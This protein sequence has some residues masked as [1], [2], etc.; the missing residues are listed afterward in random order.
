MPPCGIHFTKLKHQIL[1]V[2]HTEPSNRGVN[3]RVSNF[4]PVNIKLIQIASSVHIFISTHFTKKFLDPTGMVYS[5]ATEGDSVRNI[6]VLG[7]QQ[8]GLLLCLETTGVSY[9]N[10]TSLTS[11]QESKPKRYTPALS[12]LLDICHEQKDMQSNCF[13]VTKD[14]HTSLKHY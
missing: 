8:T 4:F 13:R 11:W 3:R 1:R 2:K 6:L 5:Q 9:F 7:S 10:H 14:N 12:T